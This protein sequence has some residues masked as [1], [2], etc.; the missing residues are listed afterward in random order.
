MPGSLKVHRI[1]TERFFQTFFVFFDV[2]F[3][4][5]MWSDSKNY[6]PLQ[7]NKIFELGHTIK[8]GLVR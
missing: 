2:F 8:L 3:F 6:V 5:E 4:L 1:Y 7:D